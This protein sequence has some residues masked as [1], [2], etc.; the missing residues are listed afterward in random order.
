MYIS[1]SYLLRFRREATD[2]VRCYSQS[3]HSRRNKEQHG[4]ACDGHTTT[5]TITTTTT[6]TRPSGNGISRGTGNHE[7]KL[8]MLQPNK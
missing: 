7:T 6:T 8:S 5:T 1:V 2:D 3:R 4:L